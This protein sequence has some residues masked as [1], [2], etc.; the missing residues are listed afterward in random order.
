MFTAWSQWV[1]DCNPSLICGHNIFMYDFPYLE[2]CASK[3]GVELRLG[4]NGEPLVIDDYESRYRVDG[5]K[6]YQYHQAR[7]YGREIVDTLFL[8]YKYDV[9]RKY[10]SYS[11]KKIIAQEGLE[12]AGR[13]HYDASQIA[14]NWYLP[15]ERA[16]IKKYAEHDADDALALFDRMVPAQFY[17][18]QSVPKP[19]QAMICSASGSQI[20]SFLVRSYLQDGHSLP[21]KSEAA[22]YEGAISIGNPGI[23]QQVFKVD[24]AS[25]YPSIILQWQLYDKQKDPRR[26][27]LQM[28]EH[29]TKERLENKR[30][31][32]E[33]GDRY[34][35]DLEQAQ[36]IVINSAYGICGAPGLLFNSPDIAGFITRAG[37][38][39]L[40]TAMDWATKFGYQ[41]V[42]AD[43]DSISITDGTEWS[44]ERCDSVLKSINGGM[45]EKIRWE[46]DGVYPRVVVLKAKNYCLDD[47]KKVKTKGS[48]LKATTKEPALREF[49]ARALQ[50]VLN[51]QK[52][53]LGSL[54]QEY[55]REIHSLDSIDRW[56][57]KR[58]L[59]ETL[60]SS[61]RTNE[62]KFRDALVGTDY[63]LGDKLYWYFDTND[64]VK[65][66]EQWRQDH[67]TLAL[68]DKLFSTVSIF[69]TLLDVKQFPN[70]TLK[71]NRALLNTL[72]ASN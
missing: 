35:S 34:F 24:V 28:V 47:G 26:N 43:T 17:L 31:A 6:Q 55:V 12:V 21:E 2:Y 29:F 15:E 52:D 3:A 49:I 71:R 62:R 58:T 10:E 30:R 38:E 33:T 41:I 13:Q 5:A 37:R 36:K 11:L 8:S 45:P 69:E 63:R 53:Q 25:L 50:L 59:T 40:S 23:Y 32:K 4:R 54:Y 72:I 42:N 20:N 67:S 60:L 9:G 68:L 70:L 64:A 66:K 44:P 51:G 22:E 61:A 46:H 7:I 27:F 19:F 16:L 56:V 48:A 65:L 39:L 18:T 57:S 1:R 14:R